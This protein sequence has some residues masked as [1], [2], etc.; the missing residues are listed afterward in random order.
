[1]TLG[2]GIAPVREL[3]SAG[4]N[5]GLGS[6][7]ANCGGVQSIFAAMKAAVLLPRISGVPYTEWPT[8]AAALAMASIGGAMAVGGDLRLG[9]IEAGAAA[10]L[11]LIQRAQTHL[12]PLN[13]PA[14]QLVHGEFG[15]GVDTVIVDGTVVVRHGRVTSVDQA[16]VLREAEGVM[17]SIA[18]RNAPLIDYGRRMSAALADV[19]A[20]LH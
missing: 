6:D 13:D 7:G 4:V 16:S 11:V 10:D 15:A 19:W 14:E 18:E 20:E 5:I 9:R 2:S 17:R 8:A 12:T 3:R 1:M